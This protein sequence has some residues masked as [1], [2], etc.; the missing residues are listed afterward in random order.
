MEY[1]SMKNFYLGLSLLIAASPLFSMETPYHNS[2]KKD[3]DEEKSI[4]DFRDIPQE[5]LK[6]EIDI[7]KKRYRKTD[8]KNTELQALNLTLKKTQLVAEQ[9]NT[10]EESVLEQF[11]KDPLFFQE[12]PFIWETFINALENGANVRT[13]QCW[14]AEVQKGHEKLKSKKIPII[15]SV[16]KGTTMQIVASAA[17]DVLAK[18]SNVAHNIRGLHQ[19]VIASSIVSSLLLSHQLLY[20]QQKKTKKPLEY[21]SMVPII[22]TA[23]YF[24]CKFLKNTNFITK[25][26]SKKFIHFV[27]GTKGSMRRQVSD[28]VACSLAVISVLKLMW[29]SADETRRDLIKN[30][31]IEM[32]ETKVI[33]PLQNLKDKLLNKTIE[34]QNSS[35]S[36]SDHMQ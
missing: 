10:I 12:H 9:W 13:T 31:A 19:A 30:E 5:K 11:H 32:Y 23:S 35:S 28:Y 24:T 21:I 16:L 6:E 29:D 22:G 15:K 3:G 1:L 4:Y 26:A 36:D 8:A 14:L 33:T 27:A 34:H 7:F 20:H 18:P 25:D 17:Y 2:L